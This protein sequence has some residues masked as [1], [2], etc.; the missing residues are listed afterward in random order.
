MDE[1]TQTVAGLPASPKIPAFKDLLYGVDGHVATITMNRPQRRN[2][3]SARLVNE[4]IVAL[5]IASADVKVGSIVLEGAGGV[6]CSGGD[7]SQMAGGGATNPPV[8]RR[9]GFVELNLAL[10]TV[11]KP[12]IAKVRLRLRRR[13]R[14]VAGAHFAIAEDTAKLGTPEIDR[15]FR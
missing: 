5:E 9:G 3:L 14:L 11:G 12:V 15:T 6:F 10:T 2:A 7:L 4:L 1:D 13:A 8:P